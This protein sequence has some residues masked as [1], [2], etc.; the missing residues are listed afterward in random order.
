VIR[1]PH[2]HHILVTALRSHMLTERPRL[3]FMHFWNAGSPESVGAVI[4]AALKHV[5]TK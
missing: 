2:A 4:A 1:E 3:F 5:S